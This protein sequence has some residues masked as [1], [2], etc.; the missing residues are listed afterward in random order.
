MS[1]IGSDADLPEGDEG[2]YSRWS[3]RKH[4]ER[5]QSTVEQDAATE[6]AEVEPPALTDKDMPALDSLDDSSDYSGFLSSEVSD[7]LRQLALR[8]LF[9]AAD[10]NL[11][12]GLDDYNDDFTCFTKL[13]H[14]V[15]GLQQLGSGDEPRTSDV[16]GSEQLSESP[17][18]EQSSPAE[19]EAERSAPSNSV[20]AEPDIEHSDDDEVLS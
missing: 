19:V 9:H 10:F 11:C 12:D 5:Q 7:E 15:S 2:F 14:V 13:D 3:S 1:R 6:P 16:Y 4:E 17:S 20:A 8:K 18:P